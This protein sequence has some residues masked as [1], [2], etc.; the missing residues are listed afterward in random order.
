MS[1]RFGFESL[2]SEAQQAYTN[3]Q[4]NNDFPA[5]GSAL[6]QLLLDEN[7][8][9]FIRESPAFLHAA[10]KLFDSRYPHLGLKARLD[11]MMTLF[12]AGY[13]LMAIKI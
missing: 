8:E 5:F 9:D 6:R 4:Q 2:P 1:F 13:I 11:G 10:T 12:C 3:F 7:L